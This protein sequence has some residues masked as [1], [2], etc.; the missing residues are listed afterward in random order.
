M[1]APKLAQLFLDRV[2]C[3]H[4]FLESVI[5]DRG[6]VFVSSFLSELMKL[7]GTKM[8]PLTAYH[9]QTDGLTEYTNRTLGAYLCTY[10]SYQ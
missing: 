10:C 8:K 7:C 4:G 3:Y 1:D 6:P 5:S 9:P 2:F